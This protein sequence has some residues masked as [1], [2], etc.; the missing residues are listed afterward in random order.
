MRS[1]LLILVIALASFVYASEEKQAP[2]IRNS[3]NPDELIREQSPDIDVDQ[4]FVL[5]NDKNENPF[6]KV[7]DEK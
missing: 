5:M 3:A 7:T 6:I 1:V 4:H 2:R